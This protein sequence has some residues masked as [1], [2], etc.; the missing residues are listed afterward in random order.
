MSTPTQR[1]GQW[2]AAFEAALQRGDVAAA[3]AL[4]GDDSYWRDLVSFTWNIRTQEG[5]AAIADM[6]QARLADV[7]PSGFVQLKARPPTADGVTEA[8]FTFETR[9]SRGRGHLRLKRP[10][11]DPADHHGGAEGL[12]GKDRAPRRIKGAEHGVHPWAQELARSG[13]KN[14][15]HPG[16]PRCSPMWWSWAAGRAAS[17]WARGC[18]GWACR[19]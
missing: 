11:L 15:A 5:R 13:R 10:S 2:L 17:C 12:R 16:L 18:A 8:W 6:L 1:A 19:T 4:F 3:T 14:E 9:L 7:A